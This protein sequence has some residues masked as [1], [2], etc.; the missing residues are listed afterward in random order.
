MT[1]R[2]MKGI[3]LTVACVFLLFSGNRIV[4]AQEITEKTTEELLWVENVMQS[5]ITQKFEEY[6]LL[7]DF[8]MTLCSENTVDDRMEYYF[9]VELEACLRYGSVE[10]MEYF[11][12][13]VGGLGI[14]VAKDGDYIEMM[15]ANRFEDQMEQSQM[16]QYIEAVSTYVTQEYERLHSYIGQQQII[17]IYMKAVVDEDGEIGLYM[18]GGDCYH[19][20]EDYSLGS[21]DE[22]HE[23]GYVCM[24]GELENIKEEQIISCNAMNQSQRSSAK[25][26]EYMTMYSSNPTTCDYQNHGTSCKKLRDRSKWNTAVYV[27]DY[28]HNDCADYISQ[29]LAYAGFPKDSTW[30]YSTEAWITVHGLRDYLQ[31]QSRIAVAVSGNIQVGYLVMNSEHIMMVTSHDGVR[32]CYSAHTNDRKNTPMILDSSYVYYSV[33]Y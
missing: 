32:W 9:L 8:R 7:G 14:Q 5:E 31:S 10:E 4:H 29:A 21:R 23:Q 13:L 15:E 6:Y 16:G 20:F 28:G 24:M 1:K 2:W 18:D 17:S 3:M 25:A 22:L 12:G 19:P 30:N 26:V 33:R 27:I 11:Q